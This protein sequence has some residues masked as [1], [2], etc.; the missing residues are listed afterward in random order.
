[1]LTFSETRFLTRISRGVLISFELITDKYPPTKPPCFGSASHTFRMSYRNMGYKKKK[2][3]GVIYTPFVS[4]LVH[5][6]PAKTR[7]TEKDATMFGFRGG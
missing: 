6:L 7:L 1:M 3:S 2:V 4:F 5:T